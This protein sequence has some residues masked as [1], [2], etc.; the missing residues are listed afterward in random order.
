MKELFCLFCMEAILVD[1]SGI[2]SVGCCCCIFRTDHKAL[3]GRNRQTQGTRQSSGGWCHWPLPVPSG[4]HRDGK[5]THG[6]GPPPARRSWNECMHMQYCKHR[7]Q[8]ALN[9]IPCICK[10]P[11]RKALPLVV[12]L[13]HGYDNGFVVFKLIRR[14]LA[15]VCSLW[16]RSR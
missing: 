8:L 4:C 9:A 2:T 14:S 5:A 11:P 12:V 10:V 13:C 15:P 3:K 16:D 6:P 7:M 1:A